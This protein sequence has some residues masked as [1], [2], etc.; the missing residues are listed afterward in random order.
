[1][2][3]FAKIKEFLGIMPQL[4]FSIKAVNFDLS[5]FHGS[6]GY[7]I[8]ENFLHKEKYPNCLLGIHGIINVYANDGD[9]KNKPQV[10]VVYDSKLLTKEDIVK[11]LEEFGLVV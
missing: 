5:K 10:T 9:E 7:F 6:L 11:K 4:T 8:S 2:K 1:M 3:I